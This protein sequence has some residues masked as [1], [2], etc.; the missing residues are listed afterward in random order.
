M[1]AHEGLRFSKERLKQYATIL[2][3]KAKTYSYL[4]APS[5]IRFRLMTSITFLKIRKRFFINPIFKIK[6]FL[7]TRTIR[8]KSLMSDIVIYFQQMFL[9]HWKALSIIITICVGLL[10]LEYS[11]HVQIGI[12]NIAHELVNSPYQDR[13]FDLYLTLVSVV[14]IFLGL[15]LAAVSIIA[16]TIGSK[17]NGNISAILKSM[18]LQSIYVISIVVLIAILLVSLFAMVLG[19]TLGVLNFYIISIF[20]FITL[21]SFWTLATSIFLFLNPSSLIKGHVYP[22]VLKN[23]KIATKD[24]LYKYDRDF[25]S[26]LQ[27]K[28]TGVLDI[29][30]DM[31]D[32]ATGQEMVQTNV[33]VEIA[34][35][36][37][38]QMSNYIAMKSRIPTNSYWF[39]QVHKFAKYNY[40]TDYEIDLSR[41]TGTTLNPKTVHDT[42]W[43]EDR[44]IQIIN[45]CLKK[46]FVARKLKQ[47]YVLVAQISMYIKW[48]NSKNK[49]DEVLFILDNLYN[50]FDRDFVGQ[51]TDKFEIYVSD[52]YIYI[53]V[54]FALSFNTDMTDG[55]KNI[56]VKKIIKPG[57]IHAQTNLPNNIKQAVENLG[58]KLEFEK[59]VAGSIKT[60][61]WHVQNLLSEQCLEFTK[62]GYKNITARMLKS[63]EIYYGDLFVQ[64]NSCISIA[65]FGRFYESYKKLSAS[66]YKSKHNFDNDKSFDALQK[67]LKEVKS[68]LFKLI[69]KAIPYFKPTDDDMPDYL[70]FAYIALSEELSQIIFEENPDNTNIMAGLLVA[71]I[72]IVDVL[73]EEIRLEAANL[74]ESGKPDVLIDHNLGFYIS[75]MNVLFTELMDISGYILLFDDVYPDRGLKSKIIPIWDSILEKKGMQ[76]I[77]LQIN[78]HNRPSLMVSDW[79]NFGFNLKRMASSKLQSLDLLWGNPYRLSLSGTTTEKPTK[80]YTSRLLENICHNSHS[81]WECPDGHDIFIVRYLLDKCTPE[82]KAELLK[83][84]KISNVYRWSK[85]EQTE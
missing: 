38:A 34:N 42:M 3:Y 59:K 55:I 75:R 28:T 2:L 62:E 85:D 54:D 11:G 84:Y 22:E 5:T 53:Y 20:A 44:F 52:A 57:F 60:T 33:I 4:F 18:R 37:F 49:I 74:L 47:Y 1:N 48:L 63:I 61:D 25:Q 58:A 26:H 39:P 35:Q 36:A 71:T 14:S 45:K 79:S 40:A 64:R 56:T 7:Y 46:L 66:L 77:V 68:K 78:R 13:L 12:T 10:I 21:V 70:G 67:Q 9:K 50:P 80:T 32:F 19:I 69:I 43:M 8:L 83:N 30:D 81:M 24:S 82:Q 16:Q 27:K 72:S 15:Y 65:A 41:Q 73:T 51:P 76:W 23:I 17:V 31:V 29:Y 6:R